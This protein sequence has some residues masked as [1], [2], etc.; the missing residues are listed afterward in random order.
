MCTTI[1]L[2]VEIRH[3][4]SVSVLADE[5][6][7]QT[8]VVGCVCVCVFSVPP[9]GTIS[10]PFSQD[11]QLIWIFSPDICRFVNIFENTSLK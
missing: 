2:H 9:D 8:L 10:P 3:S 11:S 6:L 1:A 4:L 7:S 5:L